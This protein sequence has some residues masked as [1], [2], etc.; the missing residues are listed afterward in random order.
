MPNQGW[1]EFK[2]E[3]LAELE[4]D[5]KRIPQAVADKALPR[6]VLAGAGVIRDEA[7]RLVPKRSG[8]LAKSIVARKQRRPK[9]TGVIYAVGANSKGFYAHMVEFG[10]APHWIKAKTGEKVL[11]IGTDK[12]GRVYSRRV[13]V[14]SKMVKHPGAAPRPFLRPALD[15]KHREAVEKMKASLARSIE[16]GEVV[17]WKNL[18]GW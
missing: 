13:N 7:R 10:T 16:R 17:Y 1:V 8:Q 18:K 2:V 14:Y 3:G 11:K 6:A 5:L 4:R 15:T 12:R 9:G